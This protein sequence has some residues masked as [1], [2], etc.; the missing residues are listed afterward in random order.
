M[1]SLKLIILFKW[2]NFIEC[3]MLIVSKGES[4]TG[5]KSQ[6]ELELKRMNDYQA[7]IPLKIEI[8]Q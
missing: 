2:E 6:K 4:C 7:M 3:K 1:T 8:N 5:D